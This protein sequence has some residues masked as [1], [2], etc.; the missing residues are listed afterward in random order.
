MSK[1]SNCI[2]SGSK[3]S[4]Y[5]KYKACE[6]SISSVMPHIKRKISAVLSDIECGEYRVESDC[7]DNYFCD[8]NDL[9]QATIDSYVTPEISYIIKMNNN[10]KLSFLLRFG[11]L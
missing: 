1:L 3:L 10:H 2:N 4:S 11:K 7:Y 8:F 9:T 6:N 5:Y